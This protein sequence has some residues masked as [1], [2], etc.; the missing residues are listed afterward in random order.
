[1]ATKTATYKGMAFPFQKSSQAFPAPVTDND[2][3]KQ[4]LVQIILTGRGERIMRPEFGSNA[5]AFV[6]ENNNLVLQETIRAEVMSAIAR[7]EPR[8][9]VRSVDIDRSD[10]EVTITITYIVVATRQEQSVAI[11][12]PIGGSE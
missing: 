8:A 5:Y 10:S 2:L 4:S 3:I 11:N 6:F 12:M 1:M 7:F 9:I